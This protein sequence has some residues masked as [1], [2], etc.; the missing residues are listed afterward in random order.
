MRGSEQKRIQGGEAP[1]IADDC[2]LIIEIGIEIA[3]TLWGVES[4]SSVNSSFLVKG[5][6]QHV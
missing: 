1:L 2:R 6:D 4:Q 5:V 3:K